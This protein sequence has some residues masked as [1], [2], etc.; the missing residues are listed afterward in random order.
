MA[1]PLRG[2]IMRSK[3][4][5]QDD[6]WCVFCNKDLPERGSMCSRK[7][8]FSLGYLH[9][10]ICTDLKCQDSYH[11]D[12]YGAFEFSAPYGRLKD[13]YYRDVCKI[14]K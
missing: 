11:A 12:P 7:G 13:F 8:C 1:L 5:W 6:Y 14:P 2:D 3:Q 10:G 9:I 4:Q